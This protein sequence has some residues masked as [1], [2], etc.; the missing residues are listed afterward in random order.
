MA[1]PKTGKSK[2]GREMHYSVGALIKNEEDKYL[3][4]DRKKFPLGI[5][6]IAGHIDE[7]EGEVDA[8]KREVEEETGL[9][10]NKYKLRFEEEVPWN[11]C[12]RGIKVH[13][14]YLY[15][16]EASGE[17]KQNKHEAKSIGWYTKEEIKKF[18]EEGR[19]EDVWKY[20]F[21]KLDLI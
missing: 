7:G 12:S 5:A 2:D 6:G 15:S 18:N 16:C 19:L 17:L 1:E 14:W 4:I 13:K 21:E 9:T 8:L 10:V 3:L 11:E 20:W